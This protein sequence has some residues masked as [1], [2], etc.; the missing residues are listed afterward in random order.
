MQGGGWQPPPGGSG[1]GG[2]GAPPGGGGGYGPPGGGAPPGYGG[3]PAGYAPSPYGAGGGPGAMGGAPAY[4]TYEFNE[5]EN[6]VIDKTAGRAKLWGIISTVVGVLQICF[7]CGAVSRPDM[8]TYLPTGIIAIVVGLTFL[9]VGNSLKSVVQ[10]QGN[11]MA[12]MMQAMDKISTA[13][14]IQII[15]TIIGAVLAVVIFFVVI[16]FIVAVAAT[17]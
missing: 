14:L 13:F 16:F 12:H 8:A 17:R 4:G 9:G 7:S 3:P 5:T 1:G 11:D 15:C 2:Y 6:A 10:T